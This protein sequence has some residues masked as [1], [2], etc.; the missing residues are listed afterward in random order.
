MAGKNYS[1]AFPECVKTQQMY[2]VK[3][4]NTNLGSQFEDF[5]DELPDLGNM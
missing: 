5:V 3:I 2:N 4:Y 1:I